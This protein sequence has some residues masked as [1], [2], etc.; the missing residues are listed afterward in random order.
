[1]KSPKRQFSQGLLAIG[2]LALL[3]PLCPCPV[4][5]AMA[6]DCCVPGE[7]SISGACCDHVTGPT[8]NLVPAG[9]PA[10]APAPALSID[11]VV[12][13]RF[14]PAAFQLVVARPIVARTILR[15]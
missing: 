3:L 5:A 4:N 8:Q 11:V 9:A 2:V 1:M 14:V 15:I 10:S 13:L 7:L 6:M 12:P